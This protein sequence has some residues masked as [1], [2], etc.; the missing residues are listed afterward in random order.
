MANVYRTFWYVVIVVGPIACPDRCASP[1]IVDHTPDVMGLSGVSVGVA[2]TDIVTDEEGDAEGVL[3]VVAEGEGVADGS[4]AHGT[5]LNAIIVTLAEPG[6][7]KVAN[8]VPSAPNA[9][10]LSARPHVPHGHG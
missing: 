8:K 2:D 4:E 10:G 5:L 9:N 6:Q 7:E 1:R 3:V